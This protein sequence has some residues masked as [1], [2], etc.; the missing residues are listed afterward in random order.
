M[1]INSAMQAGVTGLAANSAA[2]TQISNNI[3]NVNTTAYKRVTSDFQDIVTGSSASSTF[4]AGGVKAAFR[5]TVSTPGELAATNSS[6]DLGIDGQGFFVVSNSADLNAAQKNVLFTRDG[7]FQPDKTGC[8]VNAAG[9]YLQGWPV[10]A[11]GSVST[12]SSDLSKL[13]P[14]NISN[15]GGTAEATTQV[16]INAN[17]QSSQPLSTAVQIIPP[18]TAP[19]YDPTSTTASMSV[20]D[21]TVASSSGTKPDFEISMPVSD[22][23]GGQQNLTM[24]L[25]KT[26]ANTWAYEIWSPHVADAAGHTTSTTPKGLGQVARGTLAFTT[27]GEFDAANSTSVNLTT[28]TSGAFTTDLVIGA[29]SATTTPHWDSSLGVA[30][31]TVSLAFQGSKSALT[32]YDKDSVTQ[33]VISNGSAFGNLSKISVGDDGMV[34]AIFDNG[35]T[36]NIAQ[37]AIASFVNPNGLQAVS[38]NVYRVSRDSGAYSLK[39]PGLGGTGL[40]SPSSLE[41]SNVD[42]SQE[43]TSLIT[44]QRAYSAASK[45]ITT[46]D[47]M[48]QELLSIKQ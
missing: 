22:S 28:G 31:Q 42:L 36:R 29:S 15:I 44:T 33:T 7:S 21:P 11:D 38:G 12:D 24:S 19:A 6:L 13:Q 8:L 17:L 23:K 40:L 43:F 30:G 26:G 2:L 1:S 47:Q 37:V 48:L 10:N 35:V 27:S 45:I 34:S 16:A 4:N 18:A 14:I 46:A 32:Q 5:Q 25:I 20:Y 41:A 39:T 3:A 9:F